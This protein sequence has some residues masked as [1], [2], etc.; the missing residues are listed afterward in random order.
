MPP[1]AGAPLHARHVPRLLFDTYGWSGEAG[2][3]VGIARQRVRAS[4]EAIGRT[5]ATGDPACRSM[6]D[7]GVDAA[8]ETAASE[9]TGFVSQ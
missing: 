7:H 8:L 5:A 2:Q 9:L 3:F 4:A 1:F 6:P